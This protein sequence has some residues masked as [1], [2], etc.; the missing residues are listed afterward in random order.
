[1]SKKKIL[2][3]TPLYLLTT[4]NVI[5]A[6]QNGFSWLTWTALLLSLFVLV[7]DIVEVIRY[8]NKGN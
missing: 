1:M 6:V 3:N 8:G 5:Y 4:A 7:W 2:R